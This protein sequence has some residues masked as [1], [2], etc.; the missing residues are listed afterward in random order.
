MTPY[1]TVKPCRERNARPIVAEATATQ[2]IV[3]MR[4]RKQSGED[5]GGDDVHPGDEPGNAGRRAL[6]PERLQHLGNGVDTTEDDT[7]TELCARQPQ[8]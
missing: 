2:T 8:D 4:S 7:A 3:P 1:D 6:Q 5:R